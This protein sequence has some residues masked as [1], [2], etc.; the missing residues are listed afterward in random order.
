MAKF[1]QGINDIS[2]NPNFQSWRDKIKSLGCFAIP[3]GCFGAPF[4]LAFS[5]FFLF[6]LVYMPWYLVTL[7]SENVLI[8][9][10][11]VLAAIAVHFIANWLYGKQVLVEMRRSITQPL[12]PEAKNTSEQETKTPNRTKIGGSSEQVKVQFKKYDDSAT[13]L[14]DTETEIYLRDRLLNKGDRVFYYSIILGL[15]IS[16][17]IQ[18]VT[19]IQIWV[20]VTPEQL[21]QEFLKTGEET[22]IW[23]GLIPILAPFVVAFPLVYYL[24]KVRMSVGFITALIVGIIAH[25]LSIVVILGILIY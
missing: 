19:L 15:V 16:L 14:V 2:E 11:I 25:V 4:L 22:T 9:S 10:L 18:L 1:E 3:L 23:S 7:G 6:S 13:K 20:D 24:N 21:Q 5:F 12:T 8:G 17:S